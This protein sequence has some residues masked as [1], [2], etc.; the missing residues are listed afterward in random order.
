MTTTANEIILQRCTSD[1]SVNHTVRNAVAPAL[2]HMKWLLV[3]NMSVMRLYRSGSTKSGS[4]RSADSRIMMIDNASHQVRIYW[5]QCLG[6]D[7]RQDPGVPTPST[8]LHWY[9]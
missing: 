9:P 6:G 8:E 5:S 1:D 4:T 2:I 3:S 7:R